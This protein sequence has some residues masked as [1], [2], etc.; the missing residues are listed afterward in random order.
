MFVLNELLFYHSAGQSYSLARVLAEHALEWGV[1]AVATPFLISF[2]EAVPS[3][4]GSR[5]RRALVYLAAAAVAIVGTIALI[6]AGR[7]LLP[8][9]SPEVGLA[10]TFV[11][12][13][14]RL[15]AYS[16]VLFTLV[17]AFSAALAFRNQA[18]E[19]ELAQARA[20]A[21]LGSARAEVLAMQLQPHF[22]FNALNTIAG[23]IR[24]DPAGAERMVVG[25]GDLLRV[26]L[27]NDRPALIP[28][29]EEME[30]VRRY[31]DIQRVRFRDRLSVELDVPPELRSCLVPTFLL[32]PL[33]ENVIQHA[34]TPH[35]APV[36]LVVEARLSA[37]A[38]AGGAPGETR[39]LLLVR[40]D[41]PGPPPPER[42]SDGIGLRN[43]RERLAQL[44]G[45]AHFLELRPGE[46]GG[47][48]V[49]I[50]IPLQRN[51]R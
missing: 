14:R 4:R 6:A 29:A 26:S 18:R 17:T 3:G 21:L 32:Q 12:N 46:H 19:R 27:R 42:R 30:F 36:H 25:L 23:L 13:F 22:L 49:V 16:V 37:P 38:T 48:E 34:L 11:A 33:V 24:N 40:D 20:E 28:L 9:H 15:F 47:T 5:L 39:L 51:N 10:W 1:W 41:G 31:L 35:S 44:F 2:I 8:W 45:P 43:T 7:Y 50:S